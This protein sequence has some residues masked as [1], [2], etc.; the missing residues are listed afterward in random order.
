[1]RPNTQETMD[2]L[3]FIEKTF[4]GKL[5]FCAVYYVFRS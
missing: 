1:M 4:N 3:T 5:H 2:L